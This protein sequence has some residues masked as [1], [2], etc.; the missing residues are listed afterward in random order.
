MKDYPSDG[1]YGLREDQKN[2]VRHL[3]FSWRRDYE[4]T[5]DRYA[6]RRAIKKVRNNLP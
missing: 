1:F 5:Y 3:M 4:W 2:Y 6:L